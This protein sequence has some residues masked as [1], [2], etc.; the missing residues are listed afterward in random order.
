MNMRDLV[1]ELW[2]SRAFVFV[3]VRYKTRLLDSQMS[4]PPKRW[5][6]RSHSG[7]RR[8]LRH[9]RDVWNDMRGNLVSIRNFTVSVCARG[10]GV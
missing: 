1:R 5:C 10:D 9:R 6:T 4:A 8:Q 2:P 3:C 7:Y